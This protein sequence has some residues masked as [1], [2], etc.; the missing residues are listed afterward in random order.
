MLLKSV[1]A[2]HANYASHAS[3]SVNGADPDLA[4]DCDEEELAIMLK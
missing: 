4:I 1:A 2:H 3:A